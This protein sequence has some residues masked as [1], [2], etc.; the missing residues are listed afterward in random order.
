MTPHL[1]AEASRRITMPR[2]C[3][4]VRASGVMKEFAP[5]TIT[6]AVGA[7]SAPKKRF[8]FVASIVSGRPPAGMK[9]SAGTEK[10]SPSVSL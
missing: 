1:L 6:R 9:R 10:R 3:S 2:F 8:Q 7:P 5:S 4:S